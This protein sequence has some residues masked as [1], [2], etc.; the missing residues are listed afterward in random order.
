MVVLLG[1]LAHNVIVWARRWLA[2]HVPK[3]QLYGHKR[4]VRDV[5]HINGRLRRNVRGQLVEI[6][7]NQA[8]P[9]VRGVAR[10]LEVL[11][12]PMHIVVNWGE[13]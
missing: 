13:T 12:R 3:M 11:L 9:R 6:V 8:A 10:S 5:F 1:V 4:M 7:L 2:T